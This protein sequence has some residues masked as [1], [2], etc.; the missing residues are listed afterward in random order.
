[1]VPLVVDPQALFAAGSAVAAAGDG[2]A[3]NLTVLT[4]GFAAHTGLDAAGEVFGLGYQDAAGSLLKAAAAAVNACRQSGALIQQGASNYSKAEAASTL[5][6]G[7][8]A[9]QAPAEPAKISAPGPPGTWGKGEPPPLLWAVVQSFVDSLWPDGDVAGMHAAAASWRGFATSVIGMQGALN[10]S[11]SLLA[12]QQ[13]PEGG[14]ID[15]A[16][17]HIATGMGQ[18]FEASSKIATA[19]DNFA[20]EVGQ[21]QNAIRDLLNRLGSLTDLGHDL[22]L[23]VKGDALDEIKKIAKDVNDVLHNL[24]REARASEQAIKLGLGVVDGLVVKLEK[25]VR[26]EL[27]EFLGD[28]VGN[29]VATGFDVFANANEG[30]LKGAVGMATSMA[31]LDPRWFLIDPQGAASTWAG[32]GK[33]LWKGSIFNAL[34]NPQEASEAQLQQLKGVLHIDDWSTARPGLGLG[35][36][37]FDVAT[38]FIPGGGEA[39]AAADGAGAAARGAEAAAQAERAAGRAA[40]GLAGVVGPRGALADI[41]GKGSSLTKDLEGVTGELPKIEPPVGGQPVALPP[42]P[43]D[44]PV[45]PAP[46]A[47]DAPPGALHGP[48]AE[49]GPAEAGGPRDPAGAAPAPAHASPGGPHEPAGGPPTPAGGPREPVSA[50][51]GGPHEPAS[52]P[53]GGP[54]EPVPAAAPAS[55]A[56]SVPPAAADSAPSTIPQL[57]DHS[58]TPVQAAP[59][60]APVEPAAVASHSSPPSLSSAAPH[61]TLPEGR[62]T[63]L[64]GGGWHGPGHGGPA[65]EGTHGGPPHGGGP[66]GPGDGRT[67]G[68]HSRGS[69]GDGMPHQAGDGSE[70]H[71]EDQSSDGMS[72]EKRDEIIATP[73][74][75]RPDPSEYLSPEYIHNHL[76]K[77]ADGATR[78]MPESNLEKYGIAQRDGTSFVM[79]KTEADAM[80]QA[81]EGDLRA[82]ENELGLPERFLDSNKIVRIDISDPKEFNLRIPSG[83]EAGANEQWIPGGRLPNGASEAVVDGGQIPPDDYTVTD[84]FD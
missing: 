53:A 62:A 69:P 36:N 24:G 12:A 7:D 13:I 30:V 76:E 80:I 3:A 17:S 38:L 11:K 26:R 37:A 25:Y 10:A 63:E 9:L 21:A 70:P 51:A 77:F 41:A 4:A 14:K 42:K 46:R 23:I 29:Q 72:A 45:G 43:V 50:P 82:M 22:M 79:P 15:E 40:D 56:P 81:T 66:H 78:F 83:N 54:R 73:K 34:I 1:M 61:S 60:G 33:G 31:D 48:T 39:A 65:G 58:P 57:V 32:L 75:S 20:N 74:G 67:P 55:H 16:L 52:V 19:L 18:I 84:V 27:K 35:E 71:G 68:G 28:A 5:G 8:G 6:G 64:P 59:S 2:L 44:A 47:P 49:P